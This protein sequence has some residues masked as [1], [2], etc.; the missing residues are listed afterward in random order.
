MTTI[1]VTGATGFLGGAVCAQFIASD[2]DVDLV[3]L[4]RARSLQEGYERLLRQLSRFVSVKLAEKA[5]GQATIVLGGLMDDEPY[6]HPIMKKVTHVLHMAAN[7]SFSRSPDV[8]V[9]NYEGTLKLASRLENLPQL[10]RF[11]Y[12]GTAMV[13]GTAPP[14]VVHEDQYPVDHAQ[15]FVIYTES[16][17]RAER[18]LIG[19]HGLPLVVA[20]PS[21]I[22][23]HTE[24]GCLPSGSIFWGFR[25]VEQL[26][27]ITWS[28][29]ARIDVVPVDYVAKAVVALIQKGTLKH[30][31]YH[32]SGGVKS[33]D[34]NAII[35]AFAALNDAPRAHQD[36][37][38]VS[39]DAIE[40]RT[41]DFERL[42]GRCDELFFLRALRKYYNFAELDTV[43][44]N[45]RLK[46]EGIP[47]PPRFTSYLP[48]CLAKTNAATIAEQM[49]DAYHTL[50]RG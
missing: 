1:L 15:H 8:W 30:T 10:K 11:L 24:L 27:M 28:H 39:F 2:A 46:E 25:A 45:S 33:D 44:D 48:V 7:T 40:K 19:M 12:V 22:V 32:V 9:T 29:R 14:A 6:H 34:W 17:A 47:E 5:L 21:I 23:G 20:R 37:E 50:S 49:Q 43:F 31:T 4:V 38:R 41:A 18:A 42:M 13:C 16:K 3:L 35:N 36:Y 26:R